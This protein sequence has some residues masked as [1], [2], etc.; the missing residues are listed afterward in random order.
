M[1]VR[2]AHRGQKRSE[3]PMEVR[4]GPEVRIRMV[5]SCQVSAGSHTLVLCKTNKF[6]P[7]VVAHAFNPRGRRISEFKASLVYRV[8]SRSGRATQR[9]PVSE[10]KQTNK[11][12]Q[13]L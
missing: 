3:E 7:G 10:N 4:E 2:G 13:V 6:S 12:Q 11:D 9:N 8:S 5:L 1:K